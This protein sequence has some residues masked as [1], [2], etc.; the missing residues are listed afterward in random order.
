VTEP[1]IASVRGSCLCGGIKFEITGPLMSPLNCHCSQ[2]RKQHGAAFRSRMRVKADDVRWLQ[3]EDL[4]K[5]YETSRGYLR[6][7][8]RNC[9]SPVINKNGPNWKSP[10]EFP[11]GGA[12][13]HGIPLGLLDNPAVRPACHTF[14]DSKAAWYDITDDLPQYPGYPP[15]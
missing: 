3:G 6:G 4:I 2:C 8:C 7:F 9:G 5:F 1:N 14:V 12:P 13:Q 10:A 11:G 15:A